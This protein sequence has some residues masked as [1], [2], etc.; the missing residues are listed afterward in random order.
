MTPARILIVDDEP[1][2]IRLL[3]RRLMRRGYQ[4]SQANGREEALA[5]LQEAICDLAI[6]DFMMPGTNGVELAQ[7]CRKRQP[8]LRVLILT[9]SPVITEIEAARFEC[10]RKP[11]ENLEHLDEAVDRLVAAAQKDRAAGGKP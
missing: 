3:A 9:G 5:R 6:M 10:L 7:E 1:E 8:G 11:L 2:I 4:V